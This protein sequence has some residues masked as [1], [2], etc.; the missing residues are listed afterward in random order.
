MEIAEVLPFLADHR[1]AVLATHRTS[2]R[3]QLSN[4]FYGLADGV[5]RISVTADRFKTKNMRRD[6]RA[7]LHVTSEDF[8][9][10]ATVDCEVEL[11]PV[12]EAPGDSGL[13]ALID[14]YRSLSGEHPD[15]NEFEQAMIT[16]RR[17]VAALH[18]THTYGQR[19]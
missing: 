19:I 16:E 6:P 2:G 11:G 3:P 10:W 13:T 9:R 15:W 5:I 1:E 8:W 7:S 18:P 14:L 17:L 12:A 4:V